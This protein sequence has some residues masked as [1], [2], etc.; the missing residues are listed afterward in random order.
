MYETANLLVLLLELRFVVDEALII[1][2]QDIYIDIYKDIYIYT[3]TYPIVNCPAFLEM[4]LIDPVYI[5]R[6]NIMTQSLL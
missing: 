6:K 3:S 4:L 5:M 2:M 1:Q